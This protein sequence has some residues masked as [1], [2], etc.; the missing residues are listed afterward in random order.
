MLQKSQEMAFQ[1]EVRSQL[2]ILLQV[3]Y[4]TSQ[5][6][7]QKKL[8]AHNRQSAGDIKVKKQ[9]RTERMLLLRCWAIVVGDTKLECLLLSLAQSDIDF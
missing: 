2:P 5:K 4:S 1:S 6:K 8:L 9:I 3:N 7:Q